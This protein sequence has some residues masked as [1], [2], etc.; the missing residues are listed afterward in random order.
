VLRASRPCGSLLA[1][2]SSPARTDN[3]AVASLGAGIALRGQVAAA[4]HLEAS[5]CPGSRSCSPAVRFL[6]T[7]PSTEHILPAFL[8][9]RHARAASRL[10]QRGRS[11]DSAPY[12]VVRALSPPPAR[13]SDDADPP[14]RA[15]RT[16]RRRPRR[17]CG[18]RIRMRGIMPAP[19][20]RR[21][22]GARARTPRPCPRRAMPRRRGA[23]RTRPRKACSSCRDRG[24]RKRIATQGRSAACSS[25]SKGQA[26]T[27]GCSN[28]A[29]CALHYSFSSPLVAAGADTPGPC[30]CAHAQPTSSSILLLLLLRRDLA[31]RPS[32]LVRAASGS[33]RSRTSCLTRS[34]ATS[35]TRRNTAVGAEGGAADPRATLRIMEVITA[36][37]ME[38]SGLAAGRVGQVE[39]R[40]HHEGIMAAG[41]G[42][43]HYGGAPGRW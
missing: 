1:L 28:G 29:G 13:A 14:A 7:S 17:R 32:S 4:H 9:R 33:V 41:V 42:G 10:N 43:G 39:S 19:P 25:S 6:L 35:R 23:R 2:I 40:G 18:R 31:N 22:W 3:R 34:R 20:R 12:S 21:C 26:T 8:K 36:R 11:P 30:P 5:V 27:R 37:L 38:N 16:P 24:R 15:H